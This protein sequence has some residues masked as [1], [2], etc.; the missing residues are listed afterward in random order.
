MFQPSQRYAID[1]S[2][3]A[4]P[5]STSLSFS[6]AGKALCARNAGAICSCLAALCSIRTEGS[7]HFQSS[8]EDIFSGRRSAQHATDQQSRLADRAFLKNTGQCFSYELCRCSLLAPSCE[9]IVRSGIEQIM[10]HFVECLVDTEILH[11]LPSSNKSIISRA[12]GPKAQEKEVKY[13]KRMLRRAPSDGSEDEAVGTRLLDDECFDSPGPAFMSS[14][15]WSFSCVLGGI[16]SSMDNLPSDEQILRGIAKVLLDSDS[17]LGAVMSESCSRSLTLVP[18]IS[19]EREC[20]KRFIRLRGIVSEVLAKEHAVGRV[21]INIICRVTETLLQ[22]VYYLSATVEYNDR[23]TGDWSTNTNADLQD[24]YERARAL[25]LQR[26]YT[27]GASAYLS[28]LLRE[29]ARRHEQQQLAQL[30]ALIKDVVLRTSLQGSNK[31]FCSA[32]EGQVT[33]S[34]FSLDMLT[35]KGAPSATHRAQSNRLAEDLAAGLDRRMYELTLYAAA[36][37]DSSNSTDVL[38]LLIESA[39]DSSCPCP[40]K[41]FLFGCALR[42]EHSYSDPPAEGNDIDSDDLQRAVDSYLTNVNR[43]TP[44]A[45]EDV[46]ILGKLRRV[47]LRNF[48][49]PKLCFPTIEKEKKARILLIMCSLFDVGR[50]VHLCSSASPSQGSEG[51]LDISDVCLTARGLSYVLKETIAT[52]NTSDSSII[53][54]IFR[55]TRLLIQLPVGTDSAGGEEPLLIWARSSTR[56]AGGASLSIKFILQFFRW[57]NYMARLLTDDACPHI[58]QRIAANA[59]AN[60]SVGIEASHRLH[61]WTAELLE[62]L[63]MI[64][65]EAGQ[66]NMGL[67]KS[68]LAIAEQ[69]SSMEDELYPEEAATAGARASVKNVYA[70]RFVPAAAAQESSEGASTACA[71]DMTQLTLNPRCKR[72]AKE[73]IAKFIEMS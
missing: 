2:M 33:T 45:K 42:G 19:M 28:W 72:S 70:K 44:L 58:I 71:E 25:A 59:S 52:W 34:S 68:V 60:A 67:I 40:K 55:V 39:L 30:I 21:G 4:S 29:C 12:G 3:T 48:F 35:S 14:R 69:L 13:L 9:A 63:N 10:S 15:L 50:T 51:L 5:S 66:T 61:R 41:P 20:M 54:T 23:R 31:D 27:E 36:T 1:T 7:V 47:A 43:S 49:V 73:Y 26:A 38:S 32:L 57:M 56:D 53:Q 64:H 17:D 65:G 18:L 46:A 6:S 24:L 11:R 62:D 37:Y 22:N 8:F 16:M